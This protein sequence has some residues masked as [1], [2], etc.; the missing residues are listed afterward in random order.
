MAN[1]NVNKEAKN[2]NKEVETKKAVN[3][4]NTVKEKI[5]AI[6]VDPLNPKDNKVKVTINGKEHIIER[7]KQQKVSKAVY[8]MLVISGFV[9]EG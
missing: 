8:D 5:V 3:Q 7:G 1:N 6:P 4:G 9:V 2:E